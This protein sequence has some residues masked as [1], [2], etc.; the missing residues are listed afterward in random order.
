MTRFNMTLG[1]FSTHH[2][3]N[4]SGEG[5]TFVRFVLGAAAAASEGVSPNDTWENK[6]A[7]THQVQFRKE[8]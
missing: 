2:S 5:D 8:S 1:Y 4:V 3:T 6:H 7:F